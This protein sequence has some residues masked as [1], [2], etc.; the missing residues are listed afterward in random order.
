MLETT[1]PVSTKLRMVAFLTGILVAVLIVA[2]LDHLNVNRIKELYTFDK[3]DKGSDE[4]AEVLCV[5]LQSSV[6]CLARHTGWEGGTVLWLGNS[7]L[8]TINER[9]PGDRTM[10]E[11]LHASLRPNG[12]YVLGAAPPNANLQEHY[13]FFE[14]LSKKVKPQIL[15]LPVFF[16]DLRESGVRPNLRDAFEDKTVLTRLELTQIGQ[17]LINENAI[18]NEE[19]GPATLAGA[20][21]ME[22]AETTINQWMESVSDSWRQRG[23][24]RSLVLVSLHYLR[25]SAFGIGPQSVRKMIPARYERNLLALHAILDSATSQ[26]VRVVMYIPPIRSDVALPYDMEAY[27]QFKDDIQQLAIS[28]RLGFADLEDVVPAEDWG[29]KP[30][31]GLERKRELDFMH[32]TSAGHQRMA[33]KINELLVTELASLEPKSTSNKIRSASFER[34]IP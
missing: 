29:T 31:A 33:A 3:R 1:N 4:T 32:F 15:L 18:L 13:V 17:T 22:V 30:S 9:Q 19:S 10:V 2:K 5:D 25:N 11:L 28:R 23:T 12:H 34:S 27:N 26:G 8:P 21:T 20:S 24:Y 6:G 7:Q 14:Y 16:D